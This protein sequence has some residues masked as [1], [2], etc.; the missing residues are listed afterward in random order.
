MKANVSLKDLF[1]DMFC[2][3]LTVSSVCM[4]AAGQ[5]FQTTNEWPAVGYS[6]E[7]YYKSI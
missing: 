3:S 4:T 2:S 1:V 5:S 6:S 7:K